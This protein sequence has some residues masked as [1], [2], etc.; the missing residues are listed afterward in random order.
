MHRLKVTSTEKQFIRKCTPLWRLVMYFC[1]HNCTSPSNDYAAATTTRHSCT[2]TYLISKR[3][4]RPRVALRYSVRTI[5]NSVVNVLTWPE[6]GVATLKFQMH[7]VRQWLNPLSKFLD[8][9]LLV[10]MFLVLRSVWILL[11]GANLS[12]IH[13]SCK[14]RKLCP[15]NWLCSIVLEH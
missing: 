5:L 1:V 14:A 13:I 6:V 12:E 15:L 3:M 4:T 2:L 8:L 11:V 10:A 7:F 9:P